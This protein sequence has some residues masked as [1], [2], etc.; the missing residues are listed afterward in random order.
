MVERLLIAR[1]HAADGWSDHP[2]DILQSPS[3]AESVKALRV[4]IPQ[5][6]R[7]ALPRRSPGRN[8]ASPPRSVVQKNV[9]LDG[10]VSTRVK[11]LPCPN[12]SDVGHANS[13]EQKAD[14]LKLKYKRCT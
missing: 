7:L 2:R 9:Y 10:R 13:P 11:N 1:L 8:D 12:R 5:L 14:V 6:E 4:P 3:Y